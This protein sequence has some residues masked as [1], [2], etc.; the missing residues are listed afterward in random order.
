MQVCSA[1]VL[2]IRDGIRDLGEKFKDQPARAEDAA[3]QLF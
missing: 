1:G 3:Q 2:S